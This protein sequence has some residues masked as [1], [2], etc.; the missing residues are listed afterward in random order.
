[1]INCFYPCRN[2]G[3][4]MNG[5][6]CSVCGFDELQFAREW[7]EHAHATDAPYDLPADVDLDAD[8]EW[9]REAA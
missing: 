9:D 1:M 4:T 8:V 2:C 5:Q 7:D 6:F 3:G